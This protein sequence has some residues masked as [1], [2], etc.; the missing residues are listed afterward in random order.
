MIL[1]TLSFL[2]LDG[3]IFRNWIPLLSIQMAPFFLQF[4]L[5]YVLVRKFSPEDFG[6]YA[7]ALTFSG[8]CGH[9]L[10]YGIANLLLSGEKLDLKSLHFG[11]AG[12]I[13]FALSILV[14]GLAA[15][16][17]SEVEWLF[18]SGMSLYIGLSPLVAIFMAILRRFWR[19]SRVLIV[20]GLT[21]SV[22]LLI[23]FLLALET[24]HL[25][26]YLV[27]LGL[28]HIIILGIFLKTFIKVVGNSTGEGQI[29]LFSLGSS[30]NVLEV[31]SIVA[32]SSMEIF[33]RFLL[34][35]TFITL[36]LAGLLGTWNRLES[37]TGAVLG[38]LGVAIREKRLSNQDT[39]QAVTT[40]PYKRVVAVSALLWVVIWFWPGFE[41]AKWYLPNDYDFGRDLILLMSL[42]AAL[43]FF[44]VA[45][46]L[47][48]LIL[49]RRTKLPVAIALASVATVAAQMLVFG[50]SD[51]F[52]VALTL[53]VAEMANV[54][55]GA[56]V[57][58]RAQG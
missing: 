11:I 33:N 10:T 56:R 29:T 50:V 49:R 47:P 39:N 31:F 36:G 5:G 32:V 41:F 19:S 17:L 57:L 53:F 27:W 15:G 20:S 4:I 58:Q 48:G 8:L 12:G 25:E 52:A 30:T 45:T 23:G 14:F 44:F 22:A 6:F 40:S 9:F 13:F 16:M 28:N 54:V 18:L 46:I 26:N 34:S 55:L 42:V 38:R 2:G 3:N 1:R 24:N 43:R 51:L 35:L 7:L 21:E 37:L